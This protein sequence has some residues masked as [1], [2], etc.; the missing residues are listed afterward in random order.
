MTLSHRLPFCNSIAVK[1]LLDLHRSQLLQHD[2][3]PEAEKILSTQ[4]ARETYNEDK[5]ALENA[6]EINC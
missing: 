6:G 3:A 4:V 5:R 1:A 2:E